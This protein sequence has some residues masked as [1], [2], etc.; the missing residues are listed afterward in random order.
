VRRANRA[1]RVGLAY[2]YLSYDKQ[3]KQTAM[4]VLK[5]ILK[6]L[7]S[8]LETLPSALDGDFIRYH[9]LSID[10]LFE[11]IRECTTNFSTVFLLID[12]LDECDKREC[13]ILMPFLRRLLN[14]GVKLY[15]TARTGFQVSLTVTKSAL[16][17]LTI[18]ARQED[19]KSFVLERLETSDPEHQLNESDRQS[20]LRKILSQAN[21]M[22]VYRNRG[23]Y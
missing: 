9:G 2:I 1:L 20:V 4:K 18:S 6:Q 5:S 19:L 7:A 17:Q 12:A 13:E 10:A 16:H 8:Q 22:Y 14:S 3:E 21:G 23:Q 11:A 15:I